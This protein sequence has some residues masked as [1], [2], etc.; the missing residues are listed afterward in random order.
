MEDRTS[1]AVVLT[2]K[3]RHLFKRD[4]AEGD[5]VADHRGDPV[6]ELMSEVVYS[7]NRAHHQ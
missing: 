5:T 4:Y 2:M 6:S 3:D 1:G 7:V